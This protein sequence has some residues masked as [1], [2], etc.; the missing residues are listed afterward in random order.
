MT[1]LYS[2]AAQWGI[3]LEAVADLQRRMGLVHAVS[4]ANEGESE[5]AAQTR[6]R[7]NAARQGVSLWRNN[8][9]ALQDATGRWVRYGLCNDSAALNGQFKS[10]DLIGIQPVRIGPEHV[11]HTLGQFVSVEMK[12]PGWKYTATARET[13]Q[14]RW[15]ELVTGLG[16]SARFSTGD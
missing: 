4:V 12:A 3:P 15:I 13:A 7:L 8:V 10:G 9:G 5:A 2:W 16:G 1:Q 11:G 14:L 6:M